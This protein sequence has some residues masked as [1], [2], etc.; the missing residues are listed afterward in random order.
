MKVLLWLMIVAL[1][2]WAFADGPRHF[3]VSPSGSDSADGTTL[4]TAWRSVNRVNSE[5]LQPGDEVSFLAGSSFPGTLRITRSGTPALPIKFDSYN[6]VDGSKAEILAGYEIG[7]HV[8]NAEF[9]EL[10]GLKITGDGPSSISN[11]NSGVLLENNFPAERSFSSINVDDV[12]VSGFLYAGVEVK[13]SYYVNEQTQVTRRRGFQD[14]RFTRLDLHNNGWGGMWAGG[15]GNYPDFP[16]TYCIQNIY[17]G[18][19]RF[20]D[21]EG[22]ITPYHTGDGL[23]LWDVDGGTIEYCSSYRN[24]KYNQTARAGGIW[25]FWSTHLLIQFNESYENHTQGGDGGGFDLDG[26]VSESIVQYNYT[27]N[28]D[29]Y[30]YF[31]YQFE[32]RFRLTHN[33]I[34]RYNISENDSRAGHTPGSIHVGGDAPLREI[35]IYNNTVFISAVGLTPQSQLPSA[36]YAWGDLSGIRVR[37]NIL[38]ATDSIPLLRILNNGVT[39]QGNNYWTG[40][41]PFHIEWFGGTPINSLADFRITMGQERVSGEDSG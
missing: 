18:Y 28:N 3:Y 11:N 5:P 8:L 20:H 16:D 26:G 31:V 37:N 29:G 17:V 24:G 25:A 15:C 36:F 1:P 32:D 40:S 22:I 19:S 30:G 38:V 33:N 34:V 41:S 6:R 7:I 9:L 27:H 12:E 13:A 2:Q 23:Y 21:N 35:D 14:L 10:S 39:F 4:E